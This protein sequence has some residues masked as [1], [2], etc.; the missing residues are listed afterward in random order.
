MK[1]CTI[2]FL[3][4]SMDYSQNVPVILEFEMCSTKQCHNIPI[5]DDNVQESNETFYVTLEGTADMDRDKIRL[6][7]VNGTI[8]I[9]DADPPRCKHMLY[10]N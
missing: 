2:S 1:L 3:V 8:E 4:A 7:P 5:M 10:H 9:I 6:D